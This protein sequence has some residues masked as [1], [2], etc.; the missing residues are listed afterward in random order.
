MGTLSAKLGWGYCSKPAYDLYRD[1]FFTH[2]VVSSLG[3]SWDF[4]GTDDALSWFAPGGNYYATTGSVPYCLKWWSTSG[5]KKNDWPPLMS[6]PF[7]AKPMLWKTH[8]ITL[9]GSKASTISTS[10]GCGSCSRPVYDMCEASFFT[11]MWSLR[12]SIIFLLFYILYL[13]IF[14]HGCSYIDLF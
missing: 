1:S 12:P 9:I 13:K 5:Y 14:I 4:T 8:T 7:E 6:R 10:M 2:K 3:N 11:H